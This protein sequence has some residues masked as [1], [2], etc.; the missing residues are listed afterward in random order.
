MKV[1]ILAGGLGTRLAEQTLL[2]PKA[3]VE[4]GCK[5]ILWHIMHYFAEFGFKDFVIALGY[6]GELIKKYFLDYATLDRSL[7]VELG[8]GKV[9]YTDQ[10]ALDWTIELVDTGHNVAN[11]GR[12]KR[13]R[14]YLNDGAFFLTWCDGVSNIDL[15]SLLQFH[16]EHGR[17][18]TLSAVHPPSRFG[19]LQL[20]G[21]RVVSFKEK[22]AAAEGWINGAFYV[23]DPAIFDF[24]EGDSTQWER[25]PSEKLAAEGQLMAFCHE[26]FWQCMDTAR[27]K[28]LLQTLWD[29]GK[30]PWRNWS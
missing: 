25:E 9:Q 21:S 16:S 4:I 14:P 8:S 24:I 2:I 5:P 29:S 19:H 10:S 30:A 12:I 26:G 17:L 27:D 20:A 11:G 13:L 1:A 7:R 15:N 23:L 3:L 22:P 18:A 6:K 28:E